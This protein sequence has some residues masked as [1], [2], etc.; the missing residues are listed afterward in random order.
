MVFLIVVFLGTEI[1]I[2]VD[3]RQSGPKHCVK[4]SKKE[5]RYALSMKISGCI[6][7]YLNDKCLGGVAPET[8]M[9]GNNMPDLTPTNW[10]KNI[11][12]LKICD[13][14]NGK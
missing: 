11:G 6:A 10:A 1:L 13:P 12:S 3:K 8:Q 9:I 14:P 7:V 5:R 2:D 4:L